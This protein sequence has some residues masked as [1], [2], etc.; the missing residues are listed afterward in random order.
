MW[1]TYL[2]DIST[3]MSKEMCKRLWRKGHLS[4]RAVSERLTRDNADPALT[5]YIAKHEPAKP[6]DYQKRHKGEG[7][8]MS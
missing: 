5:G 2:S 4:P 6:K 7:E 3:N 1:E 8:T